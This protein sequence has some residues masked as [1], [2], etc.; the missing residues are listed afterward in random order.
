[1]LMP[2][3][4]NVFKDRTIIFPSETE[5]EPLIIVIDN[6]EVADSFIAQFNV[7]WNQQTRVYTGIN[8]PKKVFNEMLKTKKE[9]L[10]FGLDDIQLTQSLA[11]ELKKLEDHLNKNKISERLLFN[12]KIGKYNSPQLSKVKYLPKEYFSPVHVEIY[13]T[14]VAIIDWNKPIIT[15][16]IEKK[17][18]VNQYRKYFDL[19]WNIAK[20]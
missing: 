15:I 1:M 5:N 10:A 17:E 8:G 11:I 16:V 13:G 7:L 6:K 12:K 20:P 2:A 19:L 4:I 9:L 18:I 3:A 14:N